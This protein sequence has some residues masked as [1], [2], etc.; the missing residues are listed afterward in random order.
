MIKFLTMFILGCFA[1]LTIKSDIHAFEE[2]INLKVRFDDEFIPPPA[3]NI[4][5]RQIREIWDLCTMLTPSDPGMLRLV[6]KTVRPDEPATLYRHKKEIY[7]LYL[8]VNLSEHTLSVTSQALIIDASL[9]LLCRKKITTDRKNSKPITPDWII[10]AIIHRVSDKMALPNADFFPVFIP[11][12]PAVSAL[13]VMDAPMPK[14][15][16]IVAMPFFPEDSPA[17]ELYAEIADL[18]LMF[19]QSADIMACKKSFADAIMAATPETRNTTA[20][21][22]LH[23]GKLIPM[24]DL[25]QEINFEDFMEEKVF[26]AT[27]HANAGIIEERYR[28]RIRQEVSYRIAPPPGATDTATPLVYCS[29]PE[30]GENFSKIQNVAEVKRDLTLKLFRLRRQSPDALRN[31]ISAI[32]RLI[33]ALAVPNAKHFSSELLKIESNMRNAIL[34]DRTIQKYLDRTEQKYL[35]PERQY[36]RERRLLQQFNRLKSEEKTESERWF[37]LI[38]HR[39]YLDKRTE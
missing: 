35:P 17:Y 16:E 32:E 9:R 37:N 34:Q 27:N 8:P 22:H 31:S 24:D 15:N 26:T 10:A 28:A 19:H 30:L 5:K 3:R 11:V 2:T 14:P 29:L 18:L 39:Y 13:M 21:Y 25:P 33:I 36:A 4:V 23:F 6:I 1:L 20:F 38:E 12:F 7:R